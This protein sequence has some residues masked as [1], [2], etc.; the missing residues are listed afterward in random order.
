MH[1]REAQKFI[2]KNLMNTC[3]KI[4]IIDDFEYYSLC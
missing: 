2:L 4:F 1:L 3:W